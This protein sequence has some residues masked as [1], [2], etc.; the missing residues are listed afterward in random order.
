MEI[1]HDL[2]SHDPD[3]GPQEKSAKK[4]CV[5]FETECISLLE[6]LSHFRNGLPQ[7]HNLPA[8]L[9]IL[10]LFSRSLISRIEAAHHVPSNYVSGS[11]WWQIRLQRCNEYV[12]EVLTFWAH[13][14][15]QGA[16][17]PGSWAT[18]SLCAGSCADPL[19]CA[20]AP[21]SS[22][23]PISLSVCLSIRIII[24]IS[25]TITVKPFQII[26]LFLIKSTSKNLPGNEEEK[27]KLPEKNKIETVCFHI[28]INSVHNLIMCV[29][30]D[31]ILYKKNYI[32]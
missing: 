7:I 1:S 18:P 32:I 22:Y 24:R 21:M 13:L 25:E 28:L 17:L 9:Y 6:R 4:S 11:L 3:P 15:L 29:S 8:H 31:Q 12:T 5:S 16:G 19:L 26:S 23:A 20:G 14:H 10:Q 2:G 30:N 27:N